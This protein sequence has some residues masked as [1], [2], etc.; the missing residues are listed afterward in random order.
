M[1]KYKRTIRERFYS[2]FISHMEPQSKISWLLAVVALLLGLTGGFFAGQRYNERGAVSRIK[3]AEEKAAKAA[4]E[5]AQKAANPFLNTNPL[6]NAV[7]NPYEKVQ[8]NPFAK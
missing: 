2:L 4:L 6:K 1:P 7:T 8:I 5:E 3:T